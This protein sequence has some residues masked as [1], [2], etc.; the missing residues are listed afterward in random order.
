MASRCIACACVVAAAALL[1]ACASPLEPPRGDGRLSARARPPG[2]GDVPASAY[3]AARAETGPLLGDAATTEDYVRYALYHSPEVESAYQR[4]RAAAERMPQARAL[5]DPR[6][7]FEYDFRS[8]EAMIGAMQE[9][10]WPGTLREREAAAMRGATSAWR[11]FEAAR[12]AIA[13]RVTIAVHETAYLDAAIGITRDNLDLLSSLEQVIRARYRVGA[14]SHPELIRAQVELGELEDRLA[15]MLA[16][17]PALVAE[18]NAALNR[19]TDAAVPAMGRVAGRV[20]RESAAALAG[21]ARGANPGLLALDERVEEQRR[22]ER[23]ARLEGLP[24]FGAGVEYTFLENDMG[25]DLDGDPVKLRLALS[26]PLWREKY[27]AAAREAMALRLAIAHE[28]EGEANRVAAEV[29]RA[30]FEHTDAHRRVGLYERTLIPKAEESLRASLAGFRA[31]ETSFLDLLDTERTLLE[32]A[33]SAQRARADR[34]IALARLNR[35]VGTMLP[36]EPED[37][38]TEDQP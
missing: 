11:E 23:V 32:F 28:R 33:M 8:D 1:T 12:L 31:G 37:E 9:F 27:N 4:W 13:E 36:T 14:G 18:L 24:G 19:P 22:L 30:W 20:V 25:D 29:S 2:S 7:D 16:M 6:A 38:P 3:R 21:V 26:V 34:S 5:P 10:P 35:L 17:R 15:Q